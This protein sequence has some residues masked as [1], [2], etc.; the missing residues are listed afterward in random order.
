MKK[1]FVLAALFLGFTLT[2]N[3]LSAQTKAT[4][5]KSTTVQA[6]KSGNVVDKNKDG[7]CDHQQTK[8][9]TSGCTKFV[10]KNND[11]KCDNCVNG[12]CSKGNCNGKSA[13]TGNC[14]T[15]SSC[16]GCGNHG[17]KGNSP[18]TPAKTAQPEKK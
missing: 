15:K 9:K 5:D 13:S 16:N 18:C 3:T 12:A 2:T 6:H 10:D 7:I 14:G 1:L 8:G 17:G 11:G 4:P